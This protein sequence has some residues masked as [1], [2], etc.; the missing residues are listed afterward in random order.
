MLLLC[1][2]DNH[3]DSI[4]APLEAIGEQALMPNLYADIVEALEAK[5]AFLFM[6]GESFVVV[7]PIVEAGESKLLAWA[8]YG[9][10][11]NSIKKHFPQM[12]QIAK[13][14]GATAWQF[15]TNIPALQRYYPRLGAHFVRNQGH[16]QIWEIPVL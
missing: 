11:G 15:W 4:K 5:E 6:K 16:F 9:K 14:I 3:R 2:I 1:E 13:E 7:K 8:V 10:N 12:R